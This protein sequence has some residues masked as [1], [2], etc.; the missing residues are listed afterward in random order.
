MKKNKA[1]L[2]PDEQRTVDGLLTDLLSGRRGR[3]IISVPELL[4]VIC[5]R[6]PDFDEHAVIQYLTVLIRRKELRM[7]GSRIQFVPPGS[8]VSN[9]MPARVGKKSG[10]DESGVSGP[11]GSK[12]P[13]VS[14]TQLSRCGHLT[15]RLREEF[16]RLL[17]MDLERRGD[18]V[19]LNPW[20]LELSRR[21]P[22]LC[23][24][25]GQTVFSYTR[26]YVAILRLAERG[27]VTMR[28]E[29]SRWRVQAV[30][31]VAGSEALSALHDRPAPGPAGVSKKKIMEL[32]DLEARRDQIMEEL[33]RL[34]Q[35]IE[36][37]RFSLYCQVIVAV[38]RGSPE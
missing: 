15:G 16:D 14:L 24:T 27:A 4:N 5:R 33:A 11:R 23:N 18:E 25:V 10:E 29:N 9:P 21:Y 22:R 32:K 20:V 8:A 38:S 28:K 13:A 12:A 37:L 2:L 1:Q 3:G 19:F 7:N 26:V 17:L 30:K 36:S 31:K 35:H 6:Q 34:V